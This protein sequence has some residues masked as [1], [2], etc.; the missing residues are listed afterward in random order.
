[1]ASAREDSAGGLRRLAPA[2]GAH[3]N[4]RLLYQIDARG[5]VHLGVAPV[6]VDSPALEDGYP[7]DIGRLVPELEEVGEGPQL[8]LGQ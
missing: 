8:M 1:M 5:G 2:D 3:S 4:E 6:V 7:W